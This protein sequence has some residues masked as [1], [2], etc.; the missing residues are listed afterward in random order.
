MRVGDYKDITIGGTYYDAAAATNKT[1]S[2]QT[3][4]MEIAGI[5]PYYRYGDTPSPHHIDFISRDC[6]NALV[7]YNATNTNSGAFI[8]SALFT[9]LNGGSG[10]VSLLPADVA[11]VIIQKRGYTETKTGATASGASWNN[12]GKLWLPMEREIWGG[13]ARGEIIYGNGLAVQYPIFRG[14]MRHIVKGAG[15]QGA[16]AT[17]YIGST[18]NGSSSEFCATSASGVPNIYIASGENYVPLCF[19]VA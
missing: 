13:S 14:S 5:D 19:R 12:V 18:I 8:G 9:T 17:W 15:H 2:S 10:I 1:L 6:L 3:V 11:A 16:A 7:K 4:R